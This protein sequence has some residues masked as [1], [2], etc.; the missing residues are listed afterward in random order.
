M[1]RPSITT[2]RY[3]TQSFIPGEDHRME[4]TNGQEEHSDCA[5]S[6]RQGWVYKKGGEVIDRLRTKRPSGGGGR[7]RERIGPNTPLISAR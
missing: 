1:R 7:K 5:K 3:G 2:E 6:G 4:G